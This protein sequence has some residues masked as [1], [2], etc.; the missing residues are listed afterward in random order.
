MKHR[1]AA[2]MAAVLLIAGSTVLGAQEQPP[3]S[4]AVIPGFM[5]PFGPRMVVSDD[6]PPYTLGFSADLVGEY[7][8]PFSSILLARGRI[9]YSLLPVVDGATIATSDL[10]LVSFGLG[11]AIAYS[12]FAKL[13]LGASATAG[14]YLGVIG[15]QTGGNLF[16]SADASVGYRVLPALSIVLD[17]GYQYYLTPPS[18]DTSLPG[19]LY[20]GLSAQLGATY[21]IGVAGKRPK[22]EFVSTQFDQIFPVLSTYYDSHPFGSLVLK[23]REAGSISDVKVLVYVSEY[24]DG[25]RVCAEIGEMR[26]DEER[27]VP[28]KALF[29]DRILEITE[30]KKV[31]A[32]I[33]VEYALLGSERSKEVDRTVQ[34]HYRN[35]ITWDD[36]RKAAAFVTAKDPRVLRLAKNSV[37][38]VRDEGPAA[39]NGS[40]RQALCLL[41]TLRLHGTSYV[42]DPS[43][44]YA[45]LSID[46]LALDFLQ[47]PVETLS[48]KAGDCDDLT[49]L[50]AAMLEAVSIPTAFITTP[51]HIF[52]AFSLGMKPEEARRT[53]RRSTDLIFKNDAA[54]VPIE[55][56]LVADGFLK[57]WQAGAKEWRDS[58]TAGGA[59]F[60]PVQEAWKLYAPVGSPGS[61]AD[62]ALP[63]SSALVQAYKKRLDELINDQI[64]DKVAQLEAEMKK[65]GAGSEPANRLGVLYARFGMYDKAAALLKG[66]ADKKYFPAMV[67]LAS[68]SYLQGDMKKALDY[69]GRAA[70]AN[71][72]NACALLGLAKANAELGNAAAARQAYEQMASLDP[73]LAAQYAYLA[74]SGDEAARASSA[75]VE[76]AAPWQE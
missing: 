49:V 41:E 65:A 21:A 12:P 10:S 32:R 19:H 9:G 23:N 66:L 35:A 70:K 55:V 1:T 44:S 38:E 43:S 69:Y 75:S 31:T 62:V 52:L 60:F 47:F 22:V 68:I 11:P 24:M 73:D 67:N 72:T 51:G 16:L 59:G 30:G 37:S 74:S 7:R 58:T 54:W 5:V 20:D 2:M 33:S 26:R 14:L 39:I 50:Y 71:P 36:D 42:V 29:T 25:P 6:K 53:F 27:A 17:A 64:K 76:E 4:L 48:F 63:S 3:F 8:M 18:S 34:V 61:F 13:T 15:G 46:D 57:A 56:T 40:F 45:E 28:L